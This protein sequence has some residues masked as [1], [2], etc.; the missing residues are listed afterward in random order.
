MAVTPRNT[1]DAFLREVDEGVRQDQV[2]SLWNRY[3]I[4]AVLAIV[5]LL[6]ALGGW[7]WWREEQVRLAGVAGEDLTEAMSQLDVGNGDKAR[8]VLDRMA[9]DGPVGYRTLAQMMLA[10]D[11]AAGADNARAVKL[12]EA[13]VADSKAPQPLRDAALLKAVRLQYDTLPP[14]TVIARLKVLSVPGNPWFGIAGEMT[15]LAQV[16]AG[17]VAQAKPML[18]AIVRD[19]SLPASLRGRAAELA[20][21]L[22]VDEAMLR[23]AASAP[24]VMTVSQGK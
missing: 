6:G 8:P 12:L 4:A 11:A 23:T 2:K 24:P 9:K 15:A 16:K 3:G 7:L 18:T 17:Q 21:S 10:G 5:L 22:G 20:L 19:Q 1:D 14:A 13:I